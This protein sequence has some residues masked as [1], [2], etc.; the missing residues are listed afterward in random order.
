MLSP[1]PPTAARWLRAPGVRVSGDGRALSGSASLDHVDAGSCDERESRSSIGSPRPSGASSAPPLGIPRLDRLRQ[2]ADRELIEMLEQTERVVR[3]ANA[4]KAQIAGEIKRRSPVSA[5]HSGLAARLGERSPERLI[6]RLTGIA[7]GEARQLTATGVLL[8]DA[9]SGAAPWL[10]SVADAVASGELSVGA[11]AAVAGG[12]GERID[13]V[14]L[15]ELAVATAELVDFAR[16]ATPEETA[17]RARAV[18]DEL[19]ADGVLD[20]EKARRARRSMIWKVL[21]D[22][23]V[24][25]MNIFD[26]ES[27]AIV[28]AVVEAGAEVAAAKTEVRF[29]TQAEREAEAIRVA[30]GLADDGT[31]V[32]T[33]DQVRLDSLVDAMQLAARAAGSG[34]DPERILGDRSTGVRVHVQASDLEAGTGSGHI[35]GQSAAVSI[36]TVT[37]LVC[38][39]GILPVLFDGL[40]PIDAGRTQRLHSNRQRI[41]IAAA[42]GGCAWTGCDQPERACEMHHRE[43]W[44]GSNTTLINGIPFC[45]FHHVE[46]H[47]NGWSL[48][49]DPDGT[50]WLIPP[51]SQPTIP[52]RPLRSKSPLHRVA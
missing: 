10:A 48:S 7:A 27:W 20:R 18:R 4:A 14:S 47:A 21:P 11:A 41:A 50:I 45:R 22:G 36:A 12:L 51:P 39:S 24:R 35:E 40:M 30:A 8:Q 42:W 16:V 37:R 44:N 32:R 6:Q 19:D 5:G 2:V 34:L 52:R 25:N 13:G 1:M 15:D 33:I 3:E 31:E 49:R 9:E 28:H 46:L 26:P 29:M 23:S 17:T 43:P 38:T